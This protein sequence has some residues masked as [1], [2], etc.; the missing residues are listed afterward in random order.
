MIMAFHLAEK[1]P[2]DCDILVLGYGDVACGALKV[3]F[4]LGANVKILRKQD[5]FNESIQA[6]INEIEYNIEAD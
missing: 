4:S 6:R 1:S 2:C 3:A 5:G